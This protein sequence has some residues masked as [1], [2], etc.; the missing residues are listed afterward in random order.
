MDRKEL[1]EPDFIHKIEQ[2]RLVTRKLLAGKMKG[3]RRSKR[4]GQSVEFADYRDYS[5]GDDLR[6]LD[7]NIYGRLERLFIKLFLEEQDVN[8]YLFL[9]TSESMRFGDPSKIDYARRIAAALAYIT[10]SSNDR[11]AIGAFDGTLSR[12]FS[13]SRGKKNLWRMLDFLCDLDAEGKTNMAEAARLFTLQY[14]GKGIVVIVSDF[15]DKRGPEEAIRYFMARK[16]DIYAVH[17]LSPQEVNPDLTGDLRLVDVEDGEEA[18]ITVSA[19]LLKAY[20]RN[21][22]TFIGGI[23]DFCTRR[24]VVYAFAPTNTP[25]QDLVLNFFKKRGLV[26]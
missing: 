10:L 9:D 1:L 4:R 21:L 23:K 6:H 25:F 26:K 15:M 20:R 7:W 13:P 14:T 22:E 19:P 18:E 11:V 2:L 5:P 12:V 16:L 3:E 17:V 8:V 24:G